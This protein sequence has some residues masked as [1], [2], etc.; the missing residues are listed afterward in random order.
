MALIID[1]H[2]HLAATGVGGCYL[3]DAYQRGIAFRYLRR[4]LGLSAL[5]GEEMSAQYVAALR[6]QMDEAKGML[7]GVVLLAM[8]GRYDRE[9]R[10]DLGNTTMY[11]SN[12]Y[13]F[14]V[15]ATDPRFL[16]AASVNPRR[17]DA[18]EE[19]AR[20]AERGAVCIKT[21]ANS[22]DFDPA[23][24]AY[25]AFW[26]LMAALKLPLLQHTGREHTIPS[27]SQ[28]YGDPERL[29]PALEEGVTVIA[30]HVGSA[31]VKLPGMKET[32]DEFIGM[33]PKFPNLYG[34]ISALTS[35]GRSRYFAKMLKYPEW[36]GRLIYGSDYPIPSSPMVMVGD[37]GWAQAR[38]LSKGGNHLTRSLMVAKA[39][40]VKDDVFGRAGEVLRL[41]EEQRRKLG[42]VG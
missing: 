6:R 36:S 29:I 30:A 15:C 13:C 11:I 19:L 3:S 32:F 31:G 16:P 33:L 28:R 18:L 9:G 35:V 27:T 12:D 4:V 2:V 10:L 20:V 37:L 21:I 24:P 25:K 22:Q 23:D 39:M 14:D 7:D 41:S 26:R 8:D 38:M 5:G 1:N 17:R 42:Q 34:D 40:G